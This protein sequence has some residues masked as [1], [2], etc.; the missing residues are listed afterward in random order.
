M[1]KAK[2]IESLPGMTIMRLTRAAKSV[3]GRNW[4]AG[5]DYQPLSG[6]HDNTV[7]GKKSYRQRVNICATNEVVEFLT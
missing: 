1:L 7:H 6:G 3:D 2:R 4:P 5:T